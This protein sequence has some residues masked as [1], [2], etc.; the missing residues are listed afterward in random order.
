MRSNMKLRPVVVALMASGVLLSSVPV[1]ADGITASTQSAKNSSV[2]VGQVNAAAQGTSTL[3][4]REAQSLSQ[5]TRFNSGQSVKVLDKHELAA[6]GPVGGSA[7]AL[8][9]APGVSVSSY[10]YTGSTKTSISV[11]GIKQGWGGF[12]GGQIDNGSL[13]VTFDGVPMVNPSS[14]LWESPQVPQNGILQGIGITYGPGNPVDRWYNN[15]GGQIDFVPLQPTNKAGASIKMSYGSYD[16]KNIVFNVRTGSIDGWSTILAGGSGSSNSY[17]QTPDG[18]ANPSYNYAWFL[19]TRKTFSNGDFSLGAY[20]AKGSGYRPVSIPLNPIAGVTMNGTPNSPLY[21]QAT[22][23]YYSSL[24]E[25]VWFKQDGNT[26]WLVYS[27]LNLALDSMVGLHNTLWYRNGHRLHF[28]YNNYGLSNPG[29]LFEYNDPRTSVYGEKM[30]TDIALPY[31][32]VSVGGFFLKSQ[33]NTRQSFYNPYAP[34]FGSQQVPNAHFRSDY[35]DQTDLAAFLQD[36]ISPT[37]TLDITPGVRLITYETSYFNGGQTDFPQAYALNP[38]NNQ[39]TLPA[40][41]VS[42]AKAEP[43]IALNWRARRWLALFGNYGVAYKEPQ[44]GG[45]GGLFQSLP[46]IY[47]LEKSQD[48]NVGFKVHLPHR[49]MLRHFLLSVAYYHLDFSNQFIALTDANGNYLGDADGNSVYD[50][51]NIALAD[52]PLYNLHLFTNLNVEKATFSNYTTG[53]V[54]Y[55]GLPV[56]NVPDSTFNLGAAYKYYADHVLYVPSAWYQYIG[57]QNMFNN[58][59]GIPTQQKIPGYGTFNLALDTILPKPARDVRDIKVSFD[60]LNVFN[61]QYNFFEYITSGGFLGPSSQG[62]V[63]AV[64]GA[65]RTYYVSVSADF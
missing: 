7:Q 50:G 38:A 26:T 51:V 8:S 36:K 35:W 49:G 59:L 22:S 62:Q 57:Q 52:D 60:V 13:S 45:G 16:A 19:K 25:N 47:N 9:Y 44:V 64:P 1:M 4:S 17:R 33:Y 43:S 40:A 56:S 54:S 37:R 11:N 10:G 55:S 6:A 65:P 27:K 5:K 31:N 21:S 30:W 63:L 41:N 23:G 3:G 39:G 14:G 61:K 46:P 42:H 15:I 58:N 34:Y 2:D 20:L 48:Y 28:H 29:N 32:L 18:F 24:P 53:G 12:S